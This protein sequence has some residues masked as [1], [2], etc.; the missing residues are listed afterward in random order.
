MNLTGP[1]PSA[2]PAEGGVYKHEPYGRWQTITEK[3]YDDS[4]IDLQLPD[5]NQGGFVEV[6]P[7]IEELKVEKKPP[8][9]FKEKTA[10]TLGKNSFSKGDSM[11]KKRKASET[12][13]RNVRSRTDE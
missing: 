8:L 10:A 9:E 13:K 11:F 1:A 3:P 4:M 2:T 5:G 12:A 7:V 6:E